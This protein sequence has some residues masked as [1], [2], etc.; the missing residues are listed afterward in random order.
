VRTSLD[1][2]VPV[3][4]APLPPDDRARLRGLFLLTEKPVLYAANVAEQQLSTQDSDANV[5]AVRTLAARVGA[6]VVVL[7]ARIEAEIQQLPSEERAGFLASVGLEEPGLHKVVRAA[8]RL[9][10]LHTFFT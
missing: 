10:G 8:Y 1:A 9:L 5:Q 6:E 4:A 3:R 7:A 2:A